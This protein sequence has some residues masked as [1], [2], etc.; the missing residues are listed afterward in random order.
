MLSS[1]YILF[2]QKIKVNQRRPNGAPLT[3]LTN[4]LTSTGISG[5]GVLKGILVNKSI[6]KFKT[7]GVQSNKK[8][9]SS[10]LNVDPAATI[11]FKVDKNNFE[12]L[13]FLSGNTK[14][15]EYFTRKFDEVEMAYSRSN[16]K[17]TSPAR[18]GSYLFEIIGS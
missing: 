8:A 4:N 3:N 1:N 5:G 17:M 12:K 6:E 9:P 11:P 10:K 14:S 7:S 16:Y 13:K 2:I 15:I 18:I